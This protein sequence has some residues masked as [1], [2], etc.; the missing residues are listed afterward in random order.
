MRSAK[1]FPLLLNSP[2]TV[3]SK[4]S[5]P[6]EQRG[7]LRRSA[8]MERTLEYRANAAAAVSLATRSDDAEFKTI[9]R[10]IAQGWLELADRAE[11]GVRAA[12]ALP[13]RGRHSRPQH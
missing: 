11:K 12:T 9:M 4:F 7:C 13:A 6:S 1:Q 2:A 3:H 8:L 10:K 5:E